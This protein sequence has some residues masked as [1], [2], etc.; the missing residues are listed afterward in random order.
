MYMKVYVLI[1][2]D[3]N[4]SYYDDEPHIYIKVGRS[5]NLNERLKSI[6][7]KSQSVTTLS[8]LSL[9]EYPFGHD[10]YH[11]CPYRLYEPLYSSSYSSNGFYFSC[12]YHTESYDSNVN[13]RY[14]PFKISVK[15]EKNDVFDEL[16][17][18][19]QNKDLYK[20]RFLYDYE[21]PLVHEHSWVDLSLKSISKIED[22]NYDLLP[23]SDPFSRCNEFSIVLPCESYH[24]SLYEQI[25]INTARKFVMDHWH[26][27]IFLYNGLPSN[28]NIY[29][30]PVPS[31]LNETNDD[32]YQQI[33]E[34]IEHEFSKH[35]V[36]FS[37]SKEINACVATI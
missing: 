16:N 32:L 27:R 17:D 29:V 28:L 4:A 2:V 24:H 9:S 10:I 7:R 6:K 37:H 26:Y 12:I 34:Y 23:C 15:N 1:S 21:W 14:S 20:K 22:Y 33:G 13:E 30:N 8:P 36:S 3:L 35:N 19:E 18:M 25:A 11:I 31:N 5:A